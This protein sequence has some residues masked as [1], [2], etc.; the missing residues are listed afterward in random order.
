MIVSFSELYN[1]YVK[2][3]KNKANTIN[4]IQFQTDLVTNLWELYY[5]INRKTYEPKRYICFLVQSPKLRE[6]FASD[7]RDR[8][9]HHL[10][11]NDLEPI[12]E[13]IFIYDSYSCR[14]NKGTHKAVKRVQKFSKKENSTYYMQLDIKNFYRSYR[15]DSETSS[16]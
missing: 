5:E 14:K 16:E 12:F 15:L 8:V 13:K 6:V 10:L 1:A 7:F 11:V 4:A 9:V 3:K 2:C